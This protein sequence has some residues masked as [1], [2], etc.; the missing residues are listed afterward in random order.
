MSTTTALTDQK[1]PI[2]IRQATIADV[3]LILTFI[4][5][6]AEYEKA[7]E[8]VHATEASLKETLFGPRPFA[9]V[10]FATWEG[11]GEV[12]MALWFYNYVGLLHTLPPREWAVNTDYSASPS[13]RGSHALVSILRTL[14][15]KKNTAIK[16]SEQVFFATWQ[17]GL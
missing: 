3:P 11:V 13:P 6:L 9:H 7:P 4:R 5:L 15:S 1:P 8:R 16:K 14:S 12:A 17:K 10:V 2:S